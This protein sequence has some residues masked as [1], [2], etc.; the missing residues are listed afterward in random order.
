MGVV[1]KVLY[2]AKG[3]KAAHI[4]AQKD[5]LNPSGRLLKALKEALR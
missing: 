2:G 3:E 5:P 1:R 4:A